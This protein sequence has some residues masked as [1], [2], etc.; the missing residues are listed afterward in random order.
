MSDDAIVIIAIG[1]LLLGL[2]V[3]FA[4]RRGKDP[5]SEAFDYEKQLRRRLED[6][7][8]QDKRFEERQD[9]A[10]KQLDR[11]DEQQDRA[12]ERGRRL[13]R[14]LDK[15]EEQAR[16]QDAILDHLEKQHGI[17]K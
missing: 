16:R 7:E 11:T 12:E 10:E 15:W 17:K 2:G 6:Q 14:L 4:F 3:T 1:G 9:R 13:E 5:A 8:R